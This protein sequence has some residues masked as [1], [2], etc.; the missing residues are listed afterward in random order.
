MF[1]FPRKFSNKMKRRLLSEVERGDGV[2][3]HT[4][5]NSSSESIQG[6]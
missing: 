1:Y 5:V 2:R 3:D 4:V 6:S